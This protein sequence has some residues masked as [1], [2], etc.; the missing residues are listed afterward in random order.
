[1][2]GQEPFRAKDDK[3]RRLQRERRRERNSSGLANS[4]RILPA[5]QHMYPMIKIDGHI[6]WILDCESHGVGAFRQPDRPMQAGA[7]LRR[8]EP[9]QFRSQVRTYLVHE[10]HTT[11]SLTPGAAADQLILIFESGRCP[12]ISAT[13]GQ[14]LY[15]PPI[16]V[17]PDV[18]LVWVEKTSQMFAR[19]R[20]EKDVSANLSAQARA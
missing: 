10:R 14:E 8:G 1:M 6:E 17:A 15:S 4:A 11:S 2:S 12:V 16:R 7:P 9:T 3:R 20:V 19:L 13:T 5:R 18:P